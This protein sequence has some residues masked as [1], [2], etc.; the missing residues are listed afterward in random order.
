M[1][2]KKTLST[3]LVKKQVLGA[4][5]EASEIQLVEKSSWKVIRPS[6]TGFASMR[7]IVW[8][9]RKQGGS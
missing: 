4:P 8:V 7:V 1:S 6:A 5:S 2:Q 3:W 9:K